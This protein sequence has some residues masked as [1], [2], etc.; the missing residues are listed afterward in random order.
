EA[1]RAGPLRALP[2]AQDQARP[3]GQRPR[4]RGARSG[5]LLI[6]TLLSLSQRL[7]PALAR[8]KPL[9]QLVPASVT[10]LL[11]LLAIDPLRLIKDLRDDPRIRAILITRRARPD[12]RA[13]DRDHP[14]RHQPSFLAEHEDL[15]E[16]LADRDLVTAAK[17]RDRRMIRR[18]HRRD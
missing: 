3:P 6:Q 5:L 16:Q 12:L 2:A 1:T 8:A 18:S 15:D 7:T 4:T 10:M 13:V 17:L 9:R 11:V 14:N